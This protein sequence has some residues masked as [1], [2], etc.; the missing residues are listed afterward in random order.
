ML[1]LNLLLFALAVVLIAWF[2]F[3]FVLADAPRPGSHR[4]R[5]VLG[6][7]LQRGAAGDFFRKGTSRAYW[8]STVAVKTAP[9]A[10]EIAAGTELS[11]RINNIDGLSYENTPLPTE[12]MAEAFTATIPG[13]DEV[14]KTTFTFLEKKTTNPLRTTLA[15][16]TS[17]FLVMF[18]GGTAGATPA[19]A[20]KCDVWPV[21]VT[22][23]PRDW[24]LSKAATYKVGFTPTATPAEDV[25]VA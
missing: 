21:T 4:F 9:T 22:G 18:P 14:A 8:V 5:Y 25:A 11:D 20:D 19:A 23:R 7:R 1:H 3:G 10:A 2:L 24:D 15:K 12:N 17:G 16:G 13:P 6:W